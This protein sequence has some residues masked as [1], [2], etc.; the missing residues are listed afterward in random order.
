MHLSYRKW[1]IKIKKLSIFY[2]VAWIKRDAL[3]RISIALPIVW[4]GRWKTWGC[5]RITVTI[6][7]V[8]DWY[9]Y[10]IVSIK[11]KSLEIAIKINYFSITISQITDG[12]HARRRFCAW[13]SGRARNV[14]NHVF[15][16]GLIRISSPRT[17]A[18]Y[19]L[20]VLYM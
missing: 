14:N 8:I 10:L 12:A 13:Y 16:R 17:N 1:Q 18:K 11:N 4:A 7:H 9:A 19:K 15:C 5:T 6:L 3:I 2:T 20:W